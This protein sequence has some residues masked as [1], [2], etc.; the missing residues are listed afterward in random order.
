MK[1]LF[2][3]LL[4]IVTF[5]SCKT[6][7]QAGSA[8]SEQNISNTNT[9]QE[10][11]GSQE[12]Q[13]MPRINSNSFIYSAPSESKGLQGQ[14]NDN[15]DSLQRIINRMPNRSTLYLPDGNYYFSGTLKL[16]NKS[17]FLI[18]TGNTNF[19]FKEGVTG[20]YINK[21]NGYMP[22][23]IEGINLFSNGESGLN[24]TKK[25]G[26]GIEIH[27][28]YDL[29][30]INIRNFGENGVHTVA[31]V[32]SLNSNASF[33]LY[34]SVFVREVGGSAFYFHGGDA[35]QTLVQRCGSWD[36]AGYGFWDDSFLGNQ[37]VACMAHNSRKGH[38]RADNGNNRTTFVGCYGEQ[39]SPNSI[40]GGKTRVTGGIHGIEGKG[41]IIT[42]PYAKVNTE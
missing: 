3:V 21:N 19:Y 40:F 31:D 34:E 30:N 26:H 14:N 11:A 25:K 7:R 8:S 12:I 38:Y 41:Y 23:R 27:A 33:N 17:I 42:T 13:K 28:L 10:M 9:E 16:E 4:L 36:V 22:G 1:N 5:I 32:G 18:G 39:D 6:L 2:F 15:L 20:I 37:F 24:S 29:K 35:S